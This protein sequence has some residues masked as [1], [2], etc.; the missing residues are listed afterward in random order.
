MPGKRYNARHALDRFLYI[1]N[2][3]RRANNNLPKFHRNQMNGLGTYKGQ[4]NR[5]TLF[6]YIRHILTG[7]MIC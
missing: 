2:F 4:T 1:K 3:G 5:Q 7:G 6:L